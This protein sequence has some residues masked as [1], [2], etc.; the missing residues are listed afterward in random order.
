MVMK[1][2][3]AAAT[4]ESVEAG[5]WMRR[6][7]EH[8]A[9]FRRNYPDDRLLIVFDIDGTILDLRHMVR[10]VLLDYDREHGTDFFHGLS[11]EDVDVHENRVEEF[12]SGRTLPADTR[13]QVLAWYLDRRWQPESVLAAHR[14]YRGV[15][16]VIRWFQLQPATSVG[17]NTGRPE[18]LRDETLRSLNA[19]GREYRVEFSSELLVM[20]ER[21]G[22]DDVLDSK[23][24]GLRRL[25]VAGYR[26]FAVV[27]NEPAV[28]AALAEADASKEILFLQAQT[29]SESRRVPTPRTV[30]GHSYDLTALVAEGDLPHHVQLVWHGVNDEANV[31][32]FLGSRVHWAECDARRD[33]LGRIVLRHDSFERTP[34][35]R[36]EPVFL[37]DDF[38][39]RLHEYGR[40]VKLDMKE[41]DAILADVLAAVDTHGFH[42]VDLWFN[43][44]IE[45]LGEDG[46]RGI[47]SARPDAIVQCPVDFLA[48]LVLAAPEHACDTIKLLMSWGVNRFSVSWAGEHARV[49]LD[50]LEDF[51]CEVNLY[52]VPDLEAFLR[53][54]LMLPTSITTDFNFPAWHYFGRGAGEQHKY[55]RYK[56]DALVPP[57]TDVA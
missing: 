47:V 4:G 33:P 39:A 14:P 52:A 20:N 57:T 3:E 23:V 51:G 10:H 46:I 30:R 35:S 34:W 9:G 6:L 16:E 13:E 8:Y 17:L 38:L 22:E 21:G 19:L 41:G 50:S 1:E 43:G 28:I 7:A 5:D 11:A 25:A 37:L 12:L 40:G 49:L 42:D 54:A 56:V 2:S 29:L 24:A 48:P 18:W 31:R 27:D 32:Q 26:P 36:S 44:R 53:A 45:A 15:L 55:H